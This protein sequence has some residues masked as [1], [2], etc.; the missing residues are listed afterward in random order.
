MKA[1]GR[2]ISMLVIG[3]LVLTGCQQA[4]TKT[5]PLKK[6]TTSTATWYLYQKKGTQK[7]ISLQFQ[8]NKTVIVKDIDAIGAP[9]GENRVDDNFVNPKFKQNKAQTQLTINTS[10]Q[11]MVLKLGKKY[12]KT[13]DQKKMVGYHVT[14]GTQKKLVFGKNF[15]RW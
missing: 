6:V 12:A 8:K 9:G 14:Y 7:V 4:R 15:R 3:L 11:K 10:D 5:A 1:L 2:I 13:I